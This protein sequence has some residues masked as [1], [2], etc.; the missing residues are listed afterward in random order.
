MQK[1]I[2]KIRNKKPSIALTRATKAAQVQVLKEQGASYRDIAAMLSIGQQ[3]ISDY[4][5]MNDEV[6]GDLK[7][8]IKRKQ[9]IE[10]YHV[11]DKARVRLEK[12]LDTANFRDT[13]GLWKIARELQSPRVGFGSTGNAIQININGLKGNVSI[14]D[15]STQATE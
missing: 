8:V 1:G 6:I 10:D 11:A 7:S 13:V 15:T 3:T 14:E 5:K 4:L 2:A 9:M 12:G